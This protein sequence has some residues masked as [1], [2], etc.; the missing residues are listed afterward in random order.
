MATV[1]TPTL[2]GGTTWNVPITLTQNAASTNPGKFLLLNYDERNPVVASAA[3][4]GSTATNV[5]LVFTLPPGE[6]IADY[7][8]VEALASTTIPPAASNAAAVGASGLG[9]HGDTIKLPNSNLAPGLGTSA[10]PAAD[11]TDSPIITSASLQPGNK[12]QLIYNQPISQVV[13]PTNSE[14]G[15][16]D[17]SGNFVGGAAGNTAVS[18]NVVTAQ[19]TGAPAAAVSRFEYIP[20]ATPVIGLRD[21]F[22]A[23]PQSVS[24]APYTLVS[25]IPALVSVAYS[26]SGDTWNFT[27]NQTISNVA[28]LAS[29]PN[30]ADFDLVGENG[31]L[32]PATSA[33]ASG[34]VA[35]VTFSS[36]SGAFAP[37]DTFATSTF[38][39]VALSTNV[40]ITS[41]G[42]S[43][44]VVTSMEKPGFTAGPDLLS[45]AFNPTALTAAFT[46]DQPPFGTS[47]TPATAPSFGLDTPATG[48]LN[49]GVTPGASIVS[50]VGNVVT[51]GFPNLTTC[52]IGGSI[53]N[54]T[55]TAFN[56]EG[57]PADSAGLTA[58]QTG[59]SVSTTGS[60]TGVTGPTGPAGPAGATG[61]AGPAGAAGPAGPAGPA[62]A[63]GPAGPA[64]PRGLTGP[65]G[66]KGAKGKRGPKGGTK[67][68]KHKKATR[69]AST[70]RTVLL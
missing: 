5:G 6:T 64:G 37:E 22:T 50:T 68:K 8:G 69:H 65:K 13:L 17:S 12:I 48:N 33:S 27:Y 11:L 38:G 70:R 61:P 43:S 41:Q 51:V 10:N 47:V 57:S 34:M 7:S 42:D 54:N 20:G 66:A 46:F 25:L 60:G 52:A 59:C 14:F 58:G 49:G 4:I 23:P 35:S 32:I 67:K 44:P 63:A 55:I 56:G 24:A 21:G 40:A 1:G 9:N 2:A 28:P 36:G 18:G 30:P 19:L 29:G 15:T 53:V 62:G 31:K 26:G 39:A 45:V 16:V 3:T